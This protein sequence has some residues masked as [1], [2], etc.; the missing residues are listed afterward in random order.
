VAENAIETLRLLVVSREPS[1]LRPLWSMGESNAWHLETAGSGWE[2]MERV[3]SG[4]V[5]HLLL[6]DVPRGD[7]DS[8]HVLRWLRRLRPEVPIILLSYSGDASQEKEAVRLGARDFIVRPFKEEQLESAIRRHLSLS[9][10]RTQVCFT[11]EDIEQLSDDTYFVGTSTVM[12]TLR[13]QAELLAQANVP[14]L[15]VGEVGT[16]RETAAR[17]IHMRSVRSSFRFMKVNC[18]A[19]PGDLLEREIFGHRSTDFGDHDPS[20]PGKIE[21]CDRGT[22]FLNEIDQMPMR[23][24]EKLLHVMQTKQLVKSGAT[25]RFDVDV[26]VIATISAN[27]ERALAENTLREDLYY[28]LSA[29]TVHVPPL[30]QRKDEIPFLLQHFMHKLAKHYGLA[31]RVLSPAVLEASQRYSWP[32]NVRELESFVKRYL[33]IGDGDLTM[34]WS[35]ADIPN[36]KQS[37]HPASVAIGEGAEDEFQGFTPAPRSLKSLIDNVKSEAERSA[38]AAALEKTGW[39]RKAAARLLR[40]SYRTMLYKIE[41]YHMRLPETY[42]PLLASHQSKAPG[43]GSQGNKTTWT[44]HKSR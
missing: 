5:P 24:Q 28:R 31:P 10:D 6:L 1:L 42:S 43:N 44:G 16:G 34:G 22:I 12:Q 23:L 15:I 25:N 37:S 11:S 40:V 20:S 32:G 17:L 27:I 26:R 30:R 29:F 4:L 13:A 33:M 18:G 9:R 21:L 3:Q 35:D 36:G 41:Q 39:N 7:G 38:I 8:L 19:L 2:A 14:V